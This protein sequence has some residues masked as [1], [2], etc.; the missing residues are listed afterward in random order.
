M[1]KPT[2]LSTLSILVNH[3]VLGSK[4]HS[5]LSHRAFMLMDR[6]LFDSRSNFLLPHIVDLSSPRC[7]QWLSFFFCAKTKQQT[8]LFS[9]LLEENLEELFIAS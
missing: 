5:M 9:C 6:T 3:C 7:T 4:T 2:P 8:L 1:S